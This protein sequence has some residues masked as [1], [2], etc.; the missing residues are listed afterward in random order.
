VR[1]ALPASHCDSDPAGGLRAGMTAASS[2]GQPTAGGK[3]SELRSCWPSN[4]SVI[5]IEAEQPEVASSMYSGPSERR[6]TRQII[7]R[8]EI[9]NRLELKREIEM[10][11]AGQLTMK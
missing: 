1:D 10:F 3:N 4:A 8:T 9:Q 2:V 5:N 7:D 11:V 6:D